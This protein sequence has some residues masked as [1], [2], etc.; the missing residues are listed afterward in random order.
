MFIKY[1]LGSLE[2]LACT[3][4]KK[5]MSSPTIQYS[6]NTEQITTLFYI[7]IFGFSYLLNVEIK[8]FIVIISDC[9]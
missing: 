7:F 2:I 8:Q 6:T 5:V 4:P 9:F 3:V 1:L